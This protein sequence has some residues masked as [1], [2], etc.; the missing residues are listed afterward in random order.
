M[1]ALVPIVFILLFCFGFPLSRKKVRIIHDG[2]LSIR[3]HA[4]F[5]LMVVD[6]YRK[7]DTCP[8]T[9]VIRF[10]GSVSEEPEKSGI[11]GV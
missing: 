11:A 2:R 7:G 8:N 6:G 4:L 1:P 9:K 3:D 10:T 5:S